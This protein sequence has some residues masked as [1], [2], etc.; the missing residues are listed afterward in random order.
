MAMP[1]WTEE[2]ALRLEMNLTFIDYA[3]AEDAELQRLRAVLDC[4][5]TDV[6]RGNDNLPT[7]D[8][9]CAILHRFRSTIDD[10]NAWADWVEETHEIVRYTAECFG[11]GDEIF[12]RA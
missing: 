8:E 6:L 11:D 9:V 7:H 10:P 12:V 4:L 5:F 1:I 3:D 2:D